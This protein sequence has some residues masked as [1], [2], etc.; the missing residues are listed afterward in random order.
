[1]LHRFRSREHGIE[2]H[3]P[4]VIQRTLSKLRREHYAFISLRELVHHLELNQPLMRAVVF[5]MDDGYFDQA[6]VAA[7]IFEKFECPVTIFPVSGFLDQ[8]F[9]FWW[10]QVQYIFENSPKRTLDV[11]VHDTVLRYELR[12]RAERVRNARDLSAHYQRTCNGDVSAF[13]N[14]LATR[15]EVDVPVRAP[16]QFAPLSWEEARALEKR[17]VEFGIHTV[18]HP[19][20]ASLPEE[21]CTWE[22]E[23]SWKRL[24]EELARPLPVL[25]YPFGQPTD[26]GAREMKLVSQMH[27]MGAVTASSGSFSDHG[28]SVEVRALPR[29]PAQNDVLRVLQC[30]TGLERIKNW[31]REN[32]STS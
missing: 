32:A 8:Q 30:A 17:G 10:D 4:E 27:L 13:V 26:F 20:L 23:A 18:S 29:Y 22:I 24:Q 19:R 14:R 25:C 15:A 1:M 31:I 28:E 7:P 21:E 2:G 12:S 3:D 9:W 11:P 6:E 5:T 16:A